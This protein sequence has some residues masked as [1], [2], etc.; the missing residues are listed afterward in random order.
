[1]NRRNLTDPA[2]AE[3]G[4]YAP[5]KEVFLDSCSVAPKISESSLEGYQGRRFLAGDYSPILKEIHHVA[6]SCE[7]LFLRG[8]LDDGYFK[9]TFPNERPA[10]L[11]VIP[12]A[13]GNPRRPAPA[14]WHALHGSDAGRCP[15]GEPLLAGRGPRRRRLDPAHCGSPPRVTCD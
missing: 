8:G 9:V 10:A 5:G 1:N 4:F 14:R 7:T 2:P 15:W 6:R 12:P 3:R 11:V 13:G